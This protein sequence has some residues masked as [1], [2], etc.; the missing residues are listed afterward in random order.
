MLEL[1][2]SFSTAA[3]R[4]IF[5]TALAAILSWTSAEAANAPTT[6]LDAD[7]GDKLESLGRL[8]DEAAQGHLKSAAGQL[9][10][11]PSDKEVPVISEIVRRTAV[12]T[13]QQ[14]RP[15]GNDTIQGSGTNITRN[16]SCVVGYQDNGTNTPYHAFRWLLNGASSTPLDLGTLGNATLQSFATDANLD[17]SVVVGYGD[18]A[19][20]GPQ[21]AF[22]WT[23]PGPM[24]DLNVL[25][26]ASGPSRALGVSNDGS[27][28]VG[29][30]EFPAGAF[31]RKGAFRWAGGSFTDLIPGGTPSL[32][33]AVS[34]DGTVVVGK[35]GT[36]TA[37]SAFRWTTQ[38]A[39]MQ[40]IA[41]LAGHATAAATAVSDNGKIVAGISNPNFLDYQGVVLGWNSGTAFRWAESG[42]YAGIKDLKQLLVDNGV[43]LDNI[44]LVSVTGVSPDGQWIQGK[45]Q[46]P[47]GETTFVA[48]FCDENIVGGIG[49]CSTTAAPF[50]LGTSAPN[51]SL[52]VSAGQS[53]MTTITVTPNAGF[54]QPVSFSCGG[55]PVEAACSFNPATVTPAGGPVNTTLTITTNGGPVAL[56][57]PGSSPTMFAYALTPFGLILIGGLLYRR[58]ADD[59][60]LWTG[61]LL[62]FVIA[63][64]S[65]SSSDSS[66]PPVNSGGGTPA[67]GTPAG[68][69]TVTV[70]ASSG[71][72]S[73]GVPIQLTVTRP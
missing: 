60:S 18:I 49:N 67:T 11:G 43:N 15:A 25:A 24:E 10:V 3:R 36:S 56:L 54:T 5:L 71:G 4:H 26:G 53:A 42:P 16:G 35:A 17:C 55:L 20:G 68:T 57:S 22:R 69:S 2:T 28:I 61:L 51:N 34:A 38:N 23:S 63:L 72:S 29:E 50:T 66:T 13:S 65:C 27:V 32:A 39:S 70:T 1:G 40:P 44:T 41:P 48:Q 62:V 21:H 7:L 64:V 45:A 31:T 59:H 37:S 6:Y 47:G 12:F 46:V 14:L 8:Y 33:T 52:T 19:G 9:V 73:S 58:R 30:A